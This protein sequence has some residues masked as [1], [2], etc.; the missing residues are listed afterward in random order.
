MAASSVFMV[1]PPRPFRW[2]SSPMPPGLQM[3]DDGIATALRFPA[4][5]WSDAAELS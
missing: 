1:L 5:G 4:D 2:I 3:P